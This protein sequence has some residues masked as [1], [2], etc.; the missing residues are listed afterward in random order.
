LEHNNF[1]KGIGTELYA[2]LITKLKKTNKHSIIAAISLPNPKSIV[3]H[4][5][6][7][8]KKNGHFSEVGRKFD[9]WID[10]GYWELI[11]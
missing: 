9:K 1:G 4:E 7:G 10:V 2:A 6:M 3:L 5:K 8:F 11:L